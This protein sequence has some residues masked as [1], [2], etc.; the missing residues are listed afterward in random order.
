MI[1]VFNRKGMIYGINDKKAETLLPL[2]IEHCI[3]TNFPQEFAS[4]NNPEFKN[5][6]FDDFYIKN[7]TPYIHGIPY[8]PHSKEHLKDLITQ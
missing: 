7:K 2:I 5:A 4:N 6:K 1:D 3:Q 8:N